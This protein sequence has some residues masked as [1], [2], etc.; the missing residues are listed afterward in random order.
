MNNV[1]SRCLPWV[2]GLTLALAGIAGT[3]SGAPP[4]AG[5]AADAGLYKV[6]RVFDV[7]TRS[8]I[9]ATGAG[10]VE[11]GHDYVLVEATR[12]EARAIE[13]LG[14]VIERIESPEEFFDLFPPADSNYHDYAEMVAELE[15]AAFDHPDVF[16]LFS[17]GLSYEGRTVW[18]G[19]VS[20]NV[21]TDE[22]E[23]EVLF[24]HHQHAR[25]HLTVEMALYTLPSATPRPTASGR[26]GASTPPAWPRS[27]RP[28]PPSS[29]STSRSTTTTTEGTTPSA[30][31]RA[32]T[33]A[34][35]TGR[36]SW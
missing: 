31:T 35:P 7:E 5:E 12:K 32:T 27:T 11:V 19:K 1:P 33:P 36:S 24:T 6:P 16:A 28:A 15:Q 10:I 2:L 34:R 14:L 3:A 21:G 22:D 29:A 30:T 13:R 26:R 25:E 4:G 9:A 23:P 20:D 18:A 8:A 17:M